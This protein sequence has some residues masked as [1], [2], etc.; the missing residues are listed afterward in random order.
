MEVTLYKKGNKSTVKVSYWT[1]SRG[2]T[3]RN[4]NG[5]ISNRYLIENYFITD[6][7][8]E[9]ISIEYCT[10]ISTLLNK[11]FSEKISFREFFKA[12]H[13][14]TQSIESIIISLYTVPQSIYT[15][16]LMDW[17]TGA[18]FCD[19]E[20]SLKLIPV[21]E[22]KFRFNARGKNSTTENSFSGSNSSRNT[23]QKSP[24]FTKEAISP[25]A[26]AEKKVTSLILEAITQ[27]LD[28]DTEHSEY[29][30]TKLLSLTKLEPKI[31]REELLSVK[32]TSV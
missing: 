28:E 24:R 15:R 16:L 26:P 27:V 3:S 4:T 18:G 6:S 25:I 2:K 8:F 32:V 10:L 1:K 31:L 9:T 23:Y 21:V 13:F 5:T 29:L 14:S 17:A 19:K 30:W 20:S 22:S 11:L 12:E 7:H